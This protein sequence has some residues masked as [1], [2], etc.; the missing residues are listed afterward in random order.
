MNPGIFR[1]PTLSQEHLSVTHPALDLTPG[2]ATWRMGDAHGSLRPSYRAQRA[3]LVSLL[4]GREVP[5][6]CLPTAPCA[7]LCARA[8]LQA[9]F[10]KCKELLR[11]WRR[12][13]YLYRRGGQDHSFLRSLKSHAMTSLL[14]VIPF[15]LRF[16]E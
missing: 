15:L 5:L 6:V 1:L 12:A 16:P 9:L 13:F 8:D 7:K 11:K 3:F 4:W 2:R 10:L 14:Q